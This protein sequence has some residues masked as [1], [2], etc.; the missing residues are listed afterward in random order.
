M[1][2]MCRRSHKFSTVRHF[3]NCC[4]TIDRLS[5]YHRIK[6]KK[7][8]KLTRFKNISQKMPPCKNC[9]K[10]QAIIP[11]LQPL[12]CGRCYSLTH[13]CPMCFS[14]FKSVKCFRCDLF[15]ETPGCIGYNSDHAVTEGPRQFPLNKPLWCRDCYK[16]SPRCIQC[17]DICKVEYLLRGTI[18]H[19]DTYEILCVLCVDDLVSLTLANALP[20]V[21][22]PLIV[23][24]Y[25]TE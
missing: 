5:I 19:Y 13:A 1:C 9:G 4:V 20:I 14:V 17:G 3:A 10:R 25:I 8:K 21:G 15:L 16:T 18:E 6:R 2:F 22:I 7:L 11:L 23:C 24:Q 12:E